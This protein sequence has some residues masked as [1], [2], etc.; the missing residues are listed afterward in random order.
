MQRVTRIMAIAAIVFSG[1]TFGSPNL[2]ASAAVFRPNVAEWQFMT[3]RTT[4]PTE[5]QCY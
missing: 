3:A 2:D 1:I 5:A 4:P